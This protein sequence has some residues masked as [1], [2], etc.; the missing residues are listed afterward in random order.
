MTD[1]TKFMSLGQMVSEFIKDG[2][3]IYIEGILANRLPM[4]IIHEIIRQKLKNLRIVS[5]PN[6]IAVDQLVGADCV[7]EVEFYFLGFMTQQ[8]FA[9]MRQFRTAV[10]EGR[11]M[12]KESMGYAICMA[13]RAGAFGIPFIPLPDFRGSDLLLVRDDYKLMVSPYNSQE[14]VVLVPALRPEI[15][16]LHA[17]LAD[18]KGNIVLKEPWPDFALTTAQASHHVIVTVEEIVESGTLTPREITIPHF[19]VN[20][21]ALMPYGAAPT[22][23]NLSYEPDQN[24]IATYQRLAQTKEGFQR[25]LQE[26]ILTTKTH[27]AFLKKAGFPPK[28]I[29]SQNRFGEGGS[30]S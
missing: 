2:S 24:H 26:Y 13:L 1:L 27:D 10:E 20:A 5:A 15:L 9:T 28:W 6:G 23:L 19:L 11:V 16:I 17:H 22:A 18:T 8:G 25:Y 30:S 4:A 29:P 14:T 21:V 7:A 12:S 3:H